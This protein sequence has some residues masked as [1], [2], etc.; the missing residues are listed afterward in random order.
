MRKMRLGLLVLVALSLIGCTGRRA[1]APL[2]VP[3]VAPTAAPAI[4]AMPEAVSTPTAAVTPEKAA[5]TVWWNDAV[6]YEI[7]VRSFYDSNGDGVGDLKGLT[8]KLDYLND[9]DPVTTQDLGVTALWLMPIAESPSYHGYDVVDYYQ[10]DQE[11]G[12][13]EDFHIL[14]DEAHKRGIRV[15]VDL[16]L[17][18]T[19]SQNPWFIESR[20]GLTAEKRDWYVWK[21]QDPGMVGPN[22]QRLW[23]STDSGWYY[24]YFWS[25]MPDLNYTNPEV[26]AEADK[27]ARYWLEEMG[28][29]GFRMD[30]VRYLVEEDLDQPRPKI[31]STASNFAW[32]VQFRQSCHEIKPDALTVGE[33]WADS[34]EVA[35]YIKNGS[36]DL[37]FE[38]TLADSIL[39]AVNG[40]SAATLRIVLGQIQQLY[41]Q[42]GY[43]TFLTNH[44][45]NRVMDQVMN[46]P[47]R[48][49]LAAVTYLTLPGVPFIYYGEEIG[50][51]GSKPDELIR[52]PMQWDGGE[53]AGFTEG[54]PWEAVNGDYETVNVAAAEKAADSLWTLYR[55]L[56]QW[57]LEYASLRSG[58]LTLAES[59]V[60]SVMGYLRAGESESVVVAL[61]YG[62]KAQPVALSWK[63]SALAAGTY[64]VQDLV[65]GKTL[66]ELTVGADGSV[67]DWALPELG[68]Q[69]FMVLVLK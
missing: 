31:Q 42:G 57:R 32:L 51:T 64:T 30:A 22:A 40:G 16:V 37:A 33:A 13:A 18:H 65:S 69:Q 21:D 58:S 43:A 68:E 6:F 56:V 14:M 52:T 38:F 48:A 28:V 1:G 11:Y 44:D 25:E 47:E 60:E 66:P 4:T 67:T 41:P 63:K 19:S 62:L 24:A 10:V 36:L 29:D 27:I 23:Y 7:F 55:Q 3:T 59:G 53:G 34:D 5:S 17:N 49:R 54:K 45:Q 2:V 8:A 35:H 46:D 20:D 15:I 9:G 61:N 39:E 26:T 50:M 12:T